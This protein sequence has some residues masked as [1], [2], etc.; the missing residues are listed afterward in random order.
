MGCLRG[1]YGLHGILEGWEVSSKPNGIHSGVIKHKKRGL[2][3]RGRSPFLPGSLKTRY[4]AK[5]SRYFSAMIAATAPSPTAVAICLRIF[6]R[7]SPAAKT[8]GIEVR[9]SASVRM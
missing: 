4:S 8:P 7:T 3:F 2:S 5:P 9:H 1:G 6:L